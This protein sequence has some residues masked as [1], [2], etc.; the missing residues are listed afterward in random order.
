MSC[1]SIGP[2]R[3]ARFKRFS[4][5]FGFKKALIDL[6]RWIYVSVVGPFLSM[7]LS[8]KAEH[9]KTLDEAIDFVYGH[10]FL[11]LSVGIFQI[12]QEITGLMREVQSIA[13]RTALEIGAARGGTL[14]LLTRAA[15]PEARIISLD[16]PQAL[17][18][19]R[20][21]RWRRLL[22]ESFA[23]K[24]QK[25]CVLRGDSHAQLMKE[26][27]KKELCGNDLDVLL[28]DGD[29]SYEGVKRDFEMYSPLVRKGGI[30]M[31]H[32]I[33]PHAED[34]TVGVPRFWQ[35]VKMTHDSKEIVNDWDQGWAGIGVL[36]M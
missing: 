28:I 32:D 17:M 11:G 25:I 4:T 35:E 31:F 24:G 21:S 1:N 2:S 12:R 20:Y 16:L 7:G 9:A 27:V 29:H 36:R 13:P 5:H 18:G 19:G 3:S 14:Y 8:K 23:V 26:Q 33:A 10:S 22:Y 34:H 30:V 6:L 15:H